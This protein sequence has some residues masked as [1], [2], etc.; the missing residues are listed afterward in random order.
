MVALC[1]NLTACVLRID[2]FEAGTSSQP[3]IGPAQS[4]VED[5]SADMKTALALMPSRQVVAADSVSRTTFQLI[6]QTDEADGILNS[7][8][9]GSL[10]Q[11]AFSTVDESQ[12]FIGNSLMQV[13]LSNVTLSTACQVLMTR[14]L[15]GM[16]PDS[17][18][19]GM[20]LADEAWSLFENSC[21]AQ[22]DQML[23]SFIQKQIAGP[24]SRIA[25]N[26]SFL[27]VETGSLIWIF[28][29]I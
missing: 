21:S 18:G 22:G 6:G 25:G 19:V 11:M 12:A 7:M 26:Q 4:R 15:F 29:K 10:F 13:P 28:K 24:L 1:L 20:N 27:Y 17:G 3:S 5:A 14:S 23:K 16:L 8:S 2:K 9:H